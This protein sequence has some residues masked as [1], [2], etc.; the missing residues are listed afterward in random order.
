MTK[1]QKIEG[2]DFIYLSEGTIQ[3]RATDDPGATELWFVEHL[4]AISGSTDQVTGNMHDVHGAL[5]AL[6]HGRPIPSCP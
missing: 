5:V 3:I 6:V 1:H 2:S 4:D